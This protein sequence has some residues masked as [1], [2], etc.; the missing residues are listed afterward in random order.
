MSTPDQRLE[1]LKKLL[2]VAQEDVAT[3]ADL[4]KLTETLV[5][6]ITKEREKLVTKIEA[7]KDATSATV[8]Q[9]RAT[10]EKKDSILRYLV[11][12]QMRLSTETTDKLSKRLT[13]EVKRLE[14]KIPT[15]T[16]LSGLEAEI[17]A[18]REALVT[19]PTEI[20]ANPQSV[21]DALELLAEDDRLDI[22]AIRGLENYDELVE[23]AKTVHPSNFNLG[24]VLRS[25][26]AGTGV[27]IDNSDPNNPIISASDGAGVPAGGTTG[28][29]LKKL[30]DADG[31]A[32]WQDETGGGGG[33]VTDHG[34]LTGLADDDHTQYH[35]DARGDARYSQLGHTHT[36]SQITDF[37]TLATVATTGAYS[38]LLGTPD[39]SV[40]DEVE[41]HANL[42]AFPA[43]GNAAKFYLAQDTGLLYRWTGSAYSVISAELALGET[44]STAYRGDRGKIAYDHSQLTTSNPHNVTAAQVGLGS[45]NNTSDLAKPISTATQTA[46]DGKANTSHTHTLSHLT[47]SGATTGQVATW[48]GTAWVPDNSGGGGGG[49]TEAQAK[50]IARRY[51]VA[52]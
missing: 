5:K 29:V 17:D 34:A 4:L 26:Q 38:D 24:R 19:V 13:A 48:N 20:T 37:P 16:D 6:V 44:S 39:L 42:A 30:S 33:G 23:L 46:L 22:G 43:T 15:R 14:G 32:D 28:Q 1:K 8:A 11:N 35:T 47:Q 18:I 31:D 25:L 40:F 7:E 45:V 3:P 9:L 41:Q 12:E 27:T 50:A 10:I 36:V 2:E 51:S 21:R 49:I 52:L